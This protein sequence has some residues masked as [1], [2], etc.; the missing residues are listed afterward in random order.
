MLLQVRWWACWILF[1]AAPAFGQAVSGSLLGAVTD[2]TDATVPGATVS[3][4]EVNTGTVRTANTSESGNYVFPDLAPGTYTVA[5]TKPGF[6]KV[7]RERVDVL[8]N[9]S[10]RV[11][12]ALP[13]GDVNEIVVVDASAPILQTDRADTGRKIETIQVASM[14]LGTSRNFQNLLNLVPGANRATFQ[15]SQFF[16]AVG[17]LQT[18]VNGLPRQG[19]N[20]QLEG[21]DNNERTGLLQM[22]IPPIEAIASVDVSTSNFEAELGRAIGA[23]TNVILKSGTNTFHGA[24]YEFLKNSSLNARNF[25]DPAIGHVAYNYFGGN[26]GG[27]II[28][29][30]LFIF[31]DYLKVLDHQAN[32]NLVSIPTPDFRT[33][34]LATSTTPIYNPFT[35]NPD[36]SGRALFPNNQIPVSMINPISTKI[37]ALVPQP[38]SPGFTNNYF[39]AL[40]FTK[41]TQSFDV[42]LDFNPSVSDRVSGRFSFQRPVTSQA[43]IFGLAGGPAQGAFEATGVQN[44]YSAGINYTHIFS[45]TLIAEFRF[46]GA[47]YRNEAKQSDYGTNASAAIGIPGV[48]LDAFSSGLSGINISGY[49]SPMVGYSLNLPWV[50]S[51][52]NIDVVNSWTKT[53]GKHT[54]KWGV[55]LRRIRDDLL[56]MITYG[57]RGQF[58]FSD[59]QTSIPGART[60]FANSFASFLLDVPN[61]AGR[62]LPIWFPAYRAWQLFT[63]AQDKWSVTP[64][65]SFDIGVRWEYYPPGTPRFA[66]GFSNYDPATN[67][68]IVAGMG[69]NPKN[70]GMDTHYKNFAPRAGLAYRLTPSTVIRAGFGVSYTPF[71]DNT[72]AYNFPVNQNNTFNPLNS[73]FGPALLPS[74]Q[75][76]T[77]QAGFPPPAVAVVPP[78][79]IIPNAP[80]QVYQVVNVHFRQPYVESWNI[81]VQKALPANFSL[82]LAYVGNHGV[83]VASN[84]NI[85][86]ATVVGQGVRGQPLYAAFGRTANTNF[87][88]RGFSSH[89]H[90]LQVKFD[91]RFSGGLLI[92]TAYT[93][94]KAMGYNT[95]DD[96]GL[97]YYINGRRN[98][99]PLDFN[100]TQNFTQSYIYELPFGRNKPWLNS[101][102]ASAVAG[103]WQLSAIFSLISGSPLNFS[104]SAAGLSAPGNSQSPDQV[105]P[106]KVLHGIGLNSPWFTQSSFAPPPALAFGNVGRNV[107]SGPGLFNLDFSLFKNIPLTEQ[108]RLQLRG[109]AFSVTNTPQFSNPGVTLGNANFGYITGTVGGGRVIQLG[110]HL[111]F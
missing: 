16:N 41:D 20:L 31:G 39:A 49:S 107:I 110:A 85:N 90:A 108:V 15:H 80:N 51:E 1:A 98:Y 42:K 84:V 52:A 104:Y 54:L 65:L 111:S 11:D 13:L 86:A 58:S 106:L 17:S 23:V 102:I 26:F 18:Q 69:R 57:A 99:A 109:E 5:A 62:D 19:N 50:R 82:D 70:L 27:P 63:F 33:G 105:A 97:L 79:G 94:S 28:K 8:V 101:G 73:G 83:N 34:N 76:A 87:V 68:L 66:G 61:L 64:K 35:G 36:G 45:P 12:L 96:G 9:T 100:H 47:H 72:Y 56:A 103:G 59:G 88:F 21:I 67:S 74:G 37:L 30:K 22:V 24:G 14:P 3:I 81:A 46:G 55:D 93:W 89:Y 77:F 75:T 7:T 40:P 44:T 4:F 78:D 32:T 95:G 6:K 91:R 92:T 2:N 43:P 10:V 25:F 48:N 60:S 29:N 38:T 71:P 53:F